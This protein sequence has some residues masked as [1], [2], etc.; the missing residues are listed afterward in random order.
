MAF[1]GIRSVALILALALAAGP[2]LAEP[3][4]GAYLAARSAGVA[5]DLAAAAQWYA[6]ALQSDPENTVLLDRNL[7]VLVGLGD[8]GAARPIADRLIAAG[9]DNQLANMVLASVAATDGNWTGLLADIDAGRAVGPL[10]DG[11]TR[12]W[13]LVGQGKMAD[14]LVAFDTVTATPG[15][16][17]FGLYHKALALAHTGDFESA[18]AIMSLPPQDGFQRTRRSVLAEV[19]VLSQL[20]RNTDAIALLDQAF[21]TAPEADIAALRARLE[22]GEAVPFTFIPDARSG[23]A[24][25]YFS[26]AGTLLEEADPIIVL[27]Y[28][29]VALALRP[30][31]VESM[32]VVAEMLQRLGQFDL[33]GQAYALVP[34]E[35][36]SFES[37][38]IGRAEALRLAG[39][40]DAAIEVLTQLARTYPERP[41][42]HARLG[43][44]LRRADRN[45]EAR[46][47]YTKAIDLLGPQSPGAWIVHYMRG[48]TE[49]E[50][51]N[52]PAAEAD[53]RRALDLNPEQPQVL[54]YL[55]YSLVERGEKL[56]EALDMIER[57]VAGDPQNGAIVDSLGWVYFRLGRYDEAVI[58]LE[59]AAALE[60]VDPVINDHLGDAYWAVGRTLEAQFQWHRAL[61]FDPDEA[62]ATRIRRKLDIGLDAVLAE[63]GASPAAL[64]DGGG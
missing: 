46:A 34:A 64:A 4:P 5:D 11:L 39:N 17:A 8:F 53:L 7:T 60:P 44:L 29:R 22:A 3:A 28:A 51:E 35:S 49:H 52:W 62:E 10:V 6:D 36:A 18:A 12:A 31:H 15:L 32:L 38:E 41:A 33:A 16:R 45:E 47:A 9:A 21:G 2:A 63:E 50:L 14:A 59:K 30:D 56:D 27:L 42:V 55:G 61:S 43:D 37:A 23:L 13:A 54:N 25:V 1:S 58:Q 40:V 20:D 19:E 48:V 57:A 24:E 26:V